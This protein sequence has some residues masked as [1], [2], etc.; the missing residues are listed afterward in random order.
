[1]DCDIDAVPLLKLVLV[2]T[3]SKRPLVMTRAWPPHTETRT[4]LVTRVVI[5]VFVNFTP[6]PIDRLIELWCSFDLPLCQCIFPCRQPAAS[7]ESRQKRR[8][9]MVPRERLSFAS[10]RFYMAYTECQT[11]HGSR[12]APRLDQCHVP[13]D[14]LFRL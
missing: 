2:T 13:L 7:L 1:M 3:I 14:L 10:R 6:R 11:L 5:L 12:I 9:V 4:G 8:S